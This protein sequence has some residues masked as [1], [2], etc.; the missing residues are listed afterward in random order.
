MSDYQRYDCE[1]SAWEA[2][3]LGNEYA[4][5]RWIHIA[6]DVTAPDDNGKTLLHYSAEGG[7]TECVELMLREGCDVNAATSPAGF[8][9]LQYTALHFA[10]E[11]G[12]AACIPALIEAG[13]NLEATSVEPSETPLILAAG[14]GHEECVSLLLKAGA[15]LEA[16]DEC[17]GTALH[18]AAWKGKPS[19]VAILVQ[20]GADIDAVDTLCA[21][22][23]LHV[24]AGKKASEATEKDTLECAS[25]LLKAGSNANA[26][27]K[28]GDSVL[29]D[30]VK[31][32]RG[33]AMVALL[34]AAVDQLELD[35][36]LLRKHA[37]G[38]EALAALQNESRWRRR[39]A[40]ALIREQREMQALG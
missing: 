40:L 19:C 7:N 22:T 36:D 37:D 20:A 1:R 14:Q 3:L 38:H 8:G 39:R 23:P 33:G 12:N 21:G 15:N 16:V 28:D 5:G 32:H 6:D 10:A 30:A 27:N 11:K 18:A 26:R 24:A 25:L 13:A 34:A 9:R 2:A 35:T 4:L 29:V 17:G 31:N